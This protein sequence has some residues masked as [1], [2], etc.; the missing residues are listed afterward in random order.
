M[1]RSRHT[2]QRSLTPGA[3]G[4]PASSNLPLCLN[5]LSILTFNHIVLVVSG[6]DHVR[7]LLIAETIMQEDVVV[8]QFHTSVPEILLFGWDRLI[9]SCIVQIEVLTERQ[10][11]VR[12]SFCY[13][14][15]LLTPTRLEKKFD[16]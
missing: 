4:L 2:P 6:G 10:K 8:L 1:R 7:R 15:C 16:K 9:F 14:H 13:T 11:L 5:P 3:L 12:F